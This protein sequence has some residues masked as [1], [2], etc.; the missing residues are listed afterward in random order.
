M[1]FIIDLDE[2]AIHYDTTPPI[3]EKKFVEAILILLAFRATTEKNECD[4]PSCLE[5][6]TELKAISNILGLGM[7]D[8]KLISQ[9][10]ET[11]Q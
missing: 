1:K 7:K 3:A 9:S 10:T 11:L 6:K 2:M 8:V 4:C 5:A